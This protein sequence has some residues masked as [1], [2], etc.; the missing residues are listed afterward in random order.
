MCSIFGIGLFRGH[1][2]EDNDTLIGAISRLFKAA[3]A[4]GNR[5][6]GLSIMR[7]NKAYVLRRPLAASDLV[8]TEEYLDFMSDHI[9]LNTKVNPLMSII[10]HCRLNTQGHP[11]NNLN[12]HPQVCGHMIGVHN[13]HIGNN[14]ELFESF[15]KVITRQA[16]VDTE[17]IFQLINHFGKPA[18]AKTIDAIK[19]STPYLRGSF[20]CGMQNTRHPYNLYLFRHGNPINILYYAKM[21]IVIFATRSYYIEKAWEEWADVDGVGEPIDLLTD[22]GVAFNL[23]NRTLC[24]FR[25]RDYQA[26]KELKGNA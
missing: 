24:K 25:F 17:I 6:S 23:W 10:G 26:A 8:Q 13:G 2:L 11:S 12:N 19:K 22:H 3:E 21:G 5:A 4:G 14:H 7:E 18:K 9:D 15:E 1:R 16:E 20:A